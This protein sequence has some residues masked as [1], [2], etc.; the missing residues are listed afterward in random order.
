V[1]HPALGA[2]VGKTQNEN[3]KRKL[4]PLVTFFTNFSPL[5][6]LSATFAGYDGM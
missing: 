4:R 1:E 2:R 6:T 3:A 5:F